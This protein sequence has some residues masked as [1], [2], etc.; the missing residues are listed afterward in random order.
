MKYRCEVTSVEG[1]VQLLACN[2]LPHG[3]WFYVPGFVPAKKDGQLVDTK[4]MKKYE[5]DISRPSRSRRKQLGYANIHYLRHGRF[6]LLL[7]TH[8][9]HRF[10]EVEKYIRD[11]R[12]SPIRFAGYSISVRRG[13][14]K[15]KEGANAEPEPDNRWRSHV[16]IDRNNYNALKAYF[17]DLAVHRSAANLAAEFAQVPFEPYAPVRRQLLNIL[18]SVNRARK[19]AGYEQLPFSTLRYRRRIVRPFEPIDSGDR[20]HRF[21]HCVQELG[22]SN[23]EEDGASHNSE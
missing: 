8:G 19:E 16:E 10:Y 18:R 15:R 6:F 9:R 12:H 17:L 22:T 21:L 14:N 1:A 11:V 3:Y 4:L 5:V 20:D 7:A 2:Y 23:A 13:G